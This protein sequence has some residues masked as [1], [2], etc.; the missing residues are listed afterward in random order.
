MKIEPQLELELHQGSIQAAQRLLAE[1]EA[2]DRDGGGLGSRLT[3]MLIPLSLRLGLEEALPARRRLPGRRRARGGL[4]QV[5]DPAACRRLAVVI[6]V[7]PGEHERRLRGA[8]RREGRRGGLEELGR[9]GHGG[10]FERAR[11]GTLWW[12]WS[13][14]SERVRWWTETDWW[15]MKEGKEEREEGRGRVGEK[16]RTRSV[17]AVEGRKGRKDL[18]SPP[19]AQG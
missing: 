9:R 3:L 6:V 10:G 12:Y 16:R 11:W 5:G 19:P 1:A 4:P 13:A 17:L 8:G 18:T 2:D 7:V 15:Y 14:L